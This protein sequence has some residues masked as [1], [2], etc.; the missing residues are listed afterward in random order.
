MEHP[1]KFEPF[2][3]GPLKST[4]F[5]ALWPRIT[6]TNYKMIGLKQKKNP[7]YGPLY[8]LAFFYARPCI[9]G[10]YLAWIP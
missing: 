6:V 3:L 1:I 10:T 4:G 9:T 5:I 2:G 8:K 7:L